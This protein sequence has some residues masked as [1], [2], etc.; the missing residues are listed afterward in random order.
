MKGLKSLP[1]VDE[2]VLQLSHLEHLPHSLLIAETEQVL[3][4]R[5][6][7]LLNKL[8]YDAASIPAIV[9]KRLRRLMTPSLRRVI[10]ATGVVLHT[11]LGR[12]PLDNFRP[13]AGYCNLEYDLR[14][15]GAKKRDAHTSTL[16]ERLMGRSAI[17]VNN[18]AAAVYLVLR[19]LAAGHEAVI[20]AA[21]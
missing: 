20:F 12:A 14:R 6:N 16:L 9:E 4:G 7:A 11:N 17:L 8:P 10:N 15:V 1:S 2:I 21:S 5:R 3:A 19:E 18:N 13:V